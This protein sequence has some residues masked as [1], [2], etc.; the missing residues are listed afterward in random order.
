VKTRIL[1]YCDNENGDGEFHYDKVTNG[2]FARV[3]SHTLNLQSVLIVVPELCYD[4]EIIEQCHYQ[5]RD[6]PHIPFCT[7]EGD[8]PRKDE[9]ERVYRM[10]RYYKL[11]TGSQAKKDFNRIK[12]LLEPVIN[13]MVTNG[14]YAARCQEAA[15]ILEKCPESD[16]VANALED[17]LRYACNYGQ[18]MSFEYIQRN[19]MQDE[20]GQLVWVDMVFDTNLMRRL[21]IKKENAK[22][23]YHY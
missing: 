6:N 17:I 19:V 8:I 5:W 9:T 14:N 11:Q 20:N 16:H 12:R 1:R 4:K 18:E 22:R 21:R 3:Y 23:A 15:N 2:E 10:K 13:R 7:R